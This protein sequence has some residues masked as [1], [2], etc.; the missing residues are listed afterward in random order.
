MK[1]KKIFL[2]FL[3]I[4][5]V[6]LVSA[7]S[8]FGSSSS[9]MSISRVESKT[10]E[11][12]TTLVTMYFEDEDVEPLTFEI[13]KGEKGEIGEVGAAGLGIESITSRIS[14]DGLKTILT[15]TFT[16][17]DVAPQEIEIPNGVSVTDT[18]QS[19]NP[20]T[21]TTDIYFVLSDGSDTSD[22]PISIPNGKDGIGIESVTQE[23]D[24][25]GNIIIT[26]TYSD[27]SMGEEG[28]TIITIPY[29]NGEDGR[30]IVSVIGT[31]VDNQFII[32]IN[33]TDGTSE[34]LTP[35]TLPRVNQ[36][37]SGSGAPNRIITNQSVL[38]DYYFDRENYIIYYFDGLSYIEIINLTKNNKVTEEHTVTFDPN[39]GSFVSETTGKLIVSD[40]ENILISR[41]PQ[42]TLDGH[43]FEG[44]YTTP[45]GP[46]NPLSGKLTDLTPIYRDI[47][48]YAYYVKL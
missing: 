3:M 28:K 40:G 2:T 41:I 4:I 27:P 17:E 12:G 38:G 11:N 21:N 6:V 39:G 10:D 42:C 9:G 19:Y 16:S 26:I 18:I 47:T 43:S 23:E 48:F 20:D 36:W 1:I 44:Y 32:T 31:Q 14:E 5:T 8:I 45:E 33:Y 7:C 22:N 24:G 25:E 29:K 37:F 34:D 15:I 13:P 35:F 30:G 46:E